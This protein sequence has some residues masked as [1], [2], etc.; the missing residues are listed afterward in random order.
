MKSIILFRHADAEWDSDNGS[1]H[2]RMLAYS[3]IKAAK[4]QQRQF[5]HRQKCWRDNHQRH[6][7]RA[8]RPRSGECDC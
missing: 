5:G 1:D 7:E 3:G 8:D 6:K 2:D 4:Q